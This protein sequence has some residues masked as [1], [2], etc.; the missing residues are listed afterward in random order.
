MSQRNVFINAMI[1]CI[2]TLIGIVC[3]PLP[4]YALFGASSIM[5]AIFFLVA[6][7]N[8]SVAYLILILLVL[9]LICL[10]LSC[11]FAYKKKK[12]LFFFVLCIDVLF[13]IFYCLYN[14]VFCEVISPYFQYDL[15][16]FVPRILFCIY[17]IED[18]C[19]LLNTK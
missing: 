4:I 14:G 16:G 15:V 5:Q 19:G 18:S 13:S 2:A 7:N 3:L 9:F 11:M 8:K 6:M 10:L 1:Y 12:A 17:V